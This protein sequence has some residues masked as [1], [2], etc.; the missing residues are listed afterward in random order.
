MTALHTLTRG[1][2]ALALASASLA[3]QAFSVTLNFDGNLAT[4]AEVDNFSFS[5]SARSDV[6][7]WTDSAT[8]NFDPFLALFSR[9]NGALL[10]VSDD[11]DNPEPQV[12]PN[13]TAL[14]AGLRLTDLAAGSY[15]VAI[16]QSPN[17]PLGSWAEGYSLTAQDGVA[18]GTRNEWS[19]TISIT[20]AA[21]LPA[22][23][24]PATWAFMLAG[25]AGLGAVAR[26]HSGRPD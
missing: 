22:V 3:A 23:P 14:D 20:E 24:E 11:I 6:L 12:S 26:R 8:A 1:L 21:P 19:V 7:V 17:L 25:L 18:T 4:T 5:I 2:A 15:R 10:A 16:S 13:Q 9:G